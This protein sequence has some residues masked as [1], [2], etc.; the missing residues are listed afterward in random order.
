MTAL[1]GWT[2]MSTNPLLEMERNPE[3]LYRPFSRIPVSGTV[4]ITQATLSNGSHSHLVNGHP[5]E[6]L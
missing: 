4:D 1:V 6:V 3:Y 2:F 5:T